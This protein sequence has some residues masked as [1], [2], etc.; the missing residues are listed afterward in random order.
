MIKKVRLTR[1]PPTFPAERTSVPFGNEFPCG[2]VELQLLGGPVPQTDVAV[3]GRPL[4]RLTLRS[5]GGN[6]PWPIAGYAS[7]TSCSS[8]KRMGFMSIFHCILVLAKRP[9]SVMGVA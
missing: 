2:Q 4:A 5:T 9:S 8:R 3:T 1:P 7:I 6:S